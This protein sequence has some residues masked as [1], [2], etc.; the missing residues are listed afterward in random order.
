MHCYK[1]AGG[2]AHDFMNDKF[3]AQLVHAI[4]AGLIYAIL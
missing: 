3:Y 4:E 1:L 2:W